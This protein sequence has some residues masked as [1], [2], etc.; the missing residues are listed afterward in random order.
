MLHYERAVGRFLIL[1]YSN[2]FCQVSVLSLYSVAIDNPAR[3]TSLHPCDLSALMYFYQ[4]SVLSLYSVA[5]DNPARVT[6]LHLCDISTRTY[7]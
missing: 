7:S 6:S 2:N 1:K 3:V 5:I 4:V